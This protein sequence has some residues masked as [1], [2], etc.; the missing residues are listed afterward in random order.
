MIN[1]FLQSPNLIFH[2]FYRYRNLSVRRKNFYIF[3]RWGPCTFDLCPHPI[4]F[5]IL[6]C[7]QLVRV[8]Q[9]AQLFLHFLNSLTIRLK[10]RTFCFSYLIVYNFCYDQK[11]LCI[12]THK[13]NVCTAIL[14]TLVYGRFITILLD[15]IPKYA[16]FIATLSSFALIDCKSLNI[17]T[18]LHLTANVLERQSDSE[19]Q[20]INQQEGKHYFSQSVMCKYISQEDT[21]LVILLTFSRC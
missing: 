7:T 4:F 12:I 19:K 14:Y 11:S 2:V 3:S 16:M 8:S 10:D 9:N 1:L 5:V 13:F 21:E 20:S 6:K 18:L 17:L 15:P